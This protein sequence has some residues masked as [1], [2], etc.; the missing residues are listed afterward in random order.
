M[1]GSRIG[2]LAIQ[3]LLVA[4]LLAA[5]GALL[6]GCELDVP[7]DDPGDDDSASEV[8]AC[9]GSEP[10]IVAIGDLHGDLVAAREALRMGGV[11]DEEDR[12][13]GCQT[14]VVQV[15]DILDRGDDER[16]ILD[17]LT[18]LDEEASATGGEVVHLNGNHEIITVYGVYDYATE[19]ACEAFADLEGLD[20]DRPELEGLSDACKVRAAAFAPGG[21]YAAL[22]AE[23]PVTFIA[24]GSVFVHAGLFSSHLEYGL[25]RIND[26][27]AGWM[28]GEVE[29]PPGAVGNTSNSLVWTRAYGDEEMEDTICEITAGVLD[30][31]Q[32]DRM[33]VGHTVQ[34]EANPACDGMLWRIDTGMTAYYGGSVEV[35]EITDIDARILTDVE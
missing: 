31:L 34:L 6:E 18:R 25:D 2:G 1:D 10:R 19:G 26:E 33:V 3:L 30:A 9:A 22:L 8:D 16:A 15:G 5:A 32:L 12:W 4:G 14:T 24:G 29:E 27:V 7:P 11:L 21:P 20:L 35:L 28:R 23:Q 13:I 17:L